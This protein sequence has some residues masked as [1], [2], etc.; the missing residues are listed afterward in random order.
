[1]Q[2]QSC[3]GPRHSVPSPLAGE[4]QGGGYNRH[5][6]CFHSICFQFEAG[7]NNP[8]CFSC[9]GS[10][11]RTSFALGALSPPLSL[12]L[13]RKGGGNVVALAFANRAMSLRMHFEMCACLGAGV[14]TNG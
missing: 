1:M 5:C 12:S 11:Q 9:L 8:E 7:Q 14:G 6:I 2:C 10:A 4:G 3:E 13:P